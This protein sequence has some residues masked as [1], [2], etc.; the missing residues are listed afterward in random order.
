MLFLSFYSFTFNTM[1]SPVVSEHYLIAS[2][3]RSKPFRKRTC[4]GLF[5]TI[6]S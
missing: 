3:L 5:S 2:S 1:P 6:R 4:E